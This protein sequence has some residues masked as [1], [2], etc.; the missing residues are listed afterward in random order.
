ML[1]CSFTK[2]CLV[3]REREKHMEKGFMSEKQ[4]NEQK[5]INEQGKTIEE[6]EE[7]GKKLTEQEQLEV[8]ILIDETINEIIRQEQGWNVKKQKTEGGRKLTD[9]EKAKIDKLG[10]VFQKLGGRKKFHELKDKFPGQD[11][12]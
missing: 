9:D 10:A 1:F 2:L 6:L 3:N 7:K 5:E 11:K 4:Y 12:R 8:M